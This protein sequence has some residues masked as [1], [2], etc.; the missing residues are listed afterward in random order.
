MSVQRSVSGG[1][2]QIFPFFPRDVLPRSRVSESL[3]QA[4]VDEVDVRGL[5]MADDKIVRFDV[6]MEVVA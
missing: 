2:C 1:P 3:S 4:E 6:S 5:L